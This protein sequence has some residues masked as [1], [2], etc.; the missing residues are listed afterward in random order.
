MLVVKLR[1]AVQ[2]EGRDKMRGAEESAVVGRHAPL[3]PESQL[4][5]M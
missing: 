5:M 4:T 3:G 2:K 1:P